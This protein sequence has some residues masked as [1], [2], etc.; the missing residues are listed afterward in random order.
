VADRETWIDRAACAGQHAETFHP[1]RA[2][3]TRHI[4]DG[5]DRAE[6]VA[7]R[8]CARCPVRR[9]C[10]VDVLNFEQGYI[11]PVSGRRRAA[12]P[13]GIAGGSTP[14]QR[15]KLKTG[16]INEKAKEIEWYFMRSIAPRILTSDEKAVC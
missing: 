14:R 15:R 6:V 2:S 8:W 12:F 9:E 3:T 7:L 13:M 16:T 5:L 11:D 1:D 10:L 4:P